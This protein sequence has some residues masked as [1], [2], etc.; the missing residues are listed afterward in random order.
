MGGNT[1]VSQR[2]VDTLLKAFGLAACSQGTMNNFLFGNDHFGY[3]ETIGGGAGAGAGFDGR[4]AVHQRMTNT[5]IT[6]PEELELRYPLQLHRFAIR[7]N[8]G[9][10]GRWNGGDGILREIEFL[11]EVEMTLISQHRAVPPYGAQGGAAG[12]CGKQ[13]ILRANG[14]RETLDGVD[15]RKLFPGDRVV[16]ETPGGGG[17]GEV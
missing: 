7:Q 12:K 16:I 6:D 1:E 9:G 8:S 15:S 5:K 3:Y 13:Y 11:A 14:K 17:W 2:L 4:S 10:K